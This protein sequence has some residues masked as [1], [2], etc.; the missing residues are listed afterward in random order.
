MSTNANWP[1]VTTILAAI[2]V[3]IHRTNP[4][5]ELGRSFIYE[6][7]RKSGDKRPLVSTDRQAEKV[8]L[9]Q[10]SL[11]MQPAM[12]AKRRQ[13]KKGTHVNT[14]TDANRMQLLFEQ[15]DSKNHCT[16]KLASPGEGIFKQFDAHTQLYNRQ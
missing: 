4:I 9:R 3:T 15:Y 8:E 14:L 13:I 5:F 11:A 10:H 12:N 6:I 2:L 16:P 1:Q 7:W